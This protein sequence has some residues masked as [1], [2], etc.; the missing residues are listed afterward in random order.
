[1]PRAPLR[2]PLIIDEMKGHNIYK[3]QALYR[4][5]VPTTLRHYLYERLPR[6]MRGQFDDWDA[7]AIPFPIKP[8]ELVLPPGPYGPARL[9]RRVNKLCEEDDW[10]G[11]DW[12]G[13][14]DALGEPERKT[15]KHRKAWEWAQGLYA[16]EQLG[17]L[18]EDAT[19]V[20]VGT[21]VENVVFYLANRLRMVYATDIYGRGD[22][23]DETAHAGMLT[24][25]A[26]YAKFPYR[27]D[28][29]TVLDMDGLHLAFPDNVFDF[30]F[31]F[32][33]IEHFGGHA[34]A[35]QAVR[36]MARVI[37]PG[38]AVV[39]VSE[40]V[41]NGLPHDE[42][43]LPREIQEYLIDGMGLRPIESMDYTISPQ[44]LAHAVD[45]DE[46]GFVTKLPHI[47]LK[48]GPWY[49]TSFCLVLEK[50]DDPTQIK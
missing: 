37:R 19:A 2:E 11:E 7:R 42:F 36:E 4:Q 41:L 31:S 49:Y 43:F 1:M 8:T 20:G 12:L 10:Y 15:G 30:A 34:A 27:E 22:F 32:S 26:R 44:T 45:T 16:L 47:V 18:T 50:P 5:L 14:L 29:L 35:A 25:A 46:A 40:V 23:A 39:L 48:Y 33:S 17:L 24:D 6:E 38:G 21:G 9:D 13:Y 28:H 3:V